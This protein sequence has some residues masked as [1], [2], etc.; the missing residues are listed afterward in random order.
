L[1]PRLL[2]FSPFLF[3]QVAPVAAPVDP[4]SL[5]C[6]DGTKLVTGTH[7][8]QVQ[9]YC[10]LFDKQQCWSFQEGLVALESTATPI[11][12]CM[13]RFEW[14][15]KEGAMP[16][17]MDRFV[18]AAAKCK[19]AGKRLCS[20]YEWELA[21]EGPATRP[22]PYG[23]KH[24]KGACTNEKPYKHYSQRALESGDAKV[25]DKETKRLYQA[26][27]SGSRSKCASVF[28]VV[29]LVGNVEEWVT[30]SRPQWPHASSLK[31]GYW[32][33]PWTGCRG[34]NEAHAPMFRFYEIGFRCC[35]DPKI[36]KS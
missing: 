10:L 36:T 1:D 17:V 15:N 2:L 6:P 21:C 29:D 25:R 8:D 32:S 28:G 26:E 16:D 27:P 33:K 20:E 22:F 4:A 12:T 34:T 31:G 14:P 24:E 13:D 30:T 18:D 3:P 7:Y 5:S 9:R 19:S 11:A 35:V 23:W